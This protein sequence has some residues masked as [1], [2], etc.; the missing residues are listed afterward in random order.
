MIDYIEERHKNLVLFYDYPEVGY[1]YEKL[2]FKEID[3]WIGL[4]K[5]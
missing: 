1:F 2:G 4:L 5:K 3:R